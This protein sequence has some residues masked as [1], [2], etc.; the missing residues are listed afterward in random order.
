[1]DIKK[2]QEKA[3]KEEKERKI[4]ALEDCKSAILYNIKNKMETNKVK[5]KTISFYTNSQYDIE[6]LANKEFVEEPLDIKL[7]KEYALF[8]SDKFFLLSL[9]NK[10]YKVHEKPL[11][12]NNHI[13]ITEVNEEEA[14]KMLQQSNEIMDDLF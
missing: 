12:S 14:K 3:I 13:T 8:K 6:N 4:K 9:D 7:V 10:Y 2:L 5:K 11:K 1:L